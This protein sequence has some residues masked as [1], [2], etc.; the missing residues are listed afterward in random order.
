M[1]ELIEALK[2]ME[3]QNY[4]LLILGASL[5][6]LKIKTNFEEEIEKLVKESNNKV[7]FT[8]FIK[9]QDIYKFYDIAD[10]A[11]LPSICDD[12]APLT[13]V[14]SLVSGLPIIT[15]NSG[16]IPEYAINGSAVIIK[17]DNDL[18]N[19]LSKEIDRLLKDDEKR[20]EMGVIA[21]NVSKNLTT[22]NYYKNFYEMLE[23]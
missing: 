10:I 5:N 8:G 3:Y 19:N 18:I 21:K 9:Y 7:I 4:K 6:E 1:K 13:I 15:T 2:N 20:K 23:N 12:S 14:E 17:R 11:V 16:G 22:E